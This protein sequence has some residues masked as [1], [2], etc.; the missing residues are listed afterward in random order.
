MSEAYKEDYDDIPPGELLRRTRQRGCF[1]ACGELRERPKTHRGCIP[2]LLVQIRQKELDRISALNVVG[3]VDEIVGLLAEKMRHL[4][5]T[6]EY[7]DINQILK[8]LK[9]RLRP[10]ELHRVMSLVEPEYPREE[11]VQMP[12]YYVDRFLGI[13]KNILAAHGLIL[14]ENTLEILNP[15]EIKVGKIIL[16]DRRS[17]KVL[18]EQRKSQPL[19]VA[20]RTKKYEKYAEEVIIAYKLTT[21][22]EHNYL[23]YLSNL[24]QWLMSE[25]DEEGKESRVKIGK[26]LRMGKTKELSRKLAR[27]IINDPELL[28]YVA[29]KF[30]EWWEKTNQ[31]H[32][33]EKSALN[34]RHDFEAKAKDRKRKKPKQT[35]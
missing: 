9:R 17:P 23:S 5:E 10:T 16:Y 7:E 6:R 29:F 1:D 25:T 34:R 35:S 21:N 22:G 2:R 31:T 19:R 28:V 20:I 3:D 14:D 18:A 15:E 12:P 24:C 27:E 4:I 11:A 30:K 13:A 32:I 26:L 8:A 33:R